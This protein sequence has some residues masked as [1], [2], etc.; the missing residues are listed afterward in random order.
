MREVRP[1]PAEEPVRRFETEPGHET[2][3]DFAEFRLP[4]GKQHALIVV[5]GY[6]RYLWLQSCERQ[7]M[8]VVMRALEAAF[9]H[10]R[11]VPAEI[12]FDQMKAVII[13]DDRADGG[14]LVENREF[15]RFAGHWG[16]RIRA[17]RPYRA[18]TK[19]KVERQ[20]SNIRKSFSYRR[21]F[22]SD[23][24]LNAQA[25]RWLDTVANASASTG[26]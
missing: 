4:W 19:G 18:Q 14:R 26:R 9:V 20:V 11:G 8:A 16:L 3:V 17:C 23:A 22:A 2:Q 21:D 13:E 5:L 6:S 24:D 1:R 10:F 25:F 7:T 15:L 12:L